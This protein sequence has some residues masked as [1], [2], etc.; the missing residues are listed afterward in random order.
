MAFPARGLKKLLFW[1]LGFLL[2]I[3]V[4]P[5]GRAHT[6]PPVVQE[7]AWDTPATRELARRACFD[8]HSNETEWPAYS[9]VAPASWLIQK[10]VDQGREHL[11]FSEWQRPQ[12]HADDAAE[13]LREK[14]MPLPHYI[15]LHGQAKL[16]DAEREQLAA[17]LSKMFSTK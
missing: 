9:N 11:N 2:V 8:C 6:N 3:Q 5:Y 14:E 17:S 10:D 1:G 12:E 16:T 15:W 4:I 7:P 13:Q